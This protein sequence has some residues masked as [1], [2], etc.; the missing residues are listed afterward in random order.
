MVFLITNTRCSKH[1]EAAKIWIKKI[2]LKSMH[3]Y[4][5]ITYIA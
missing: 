5:Y 1:A 3:L 2:N 4:V